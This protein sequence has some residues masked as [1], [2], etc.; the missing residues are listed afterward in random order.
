MPKS[1][2]EYYIEL[3]VN[4]REESERSNSKVL[5]FSRISGGFIFEIVPEDVPVMLTKTGDAFCASVKV[6]HSL[7]LLSLTTK[8]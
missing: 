4:A 8:T 5:F 6:L 3:F 7:I 2:A 1:N